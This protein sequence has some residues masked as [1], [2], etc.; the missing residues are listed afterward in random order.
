MPNVLQGEGEYGPDLGDIPG[1]PPG[2]NHNDYAFPASH[3]AK[4]EATRLIQ[5]LTSFVERAHGLRIQ[6]LVAEL[7]QAHPDVF[8]LLAV[9]AVQWDTRSSKGRLGTFTD[10]W[11]DFMAGIGPP[12][13]PQVPGK[14]G[15]APGLL[16]S[17][18][19]Q[20]LIMSERAGF[21][22]GLGAGGYPVKSPPISPGHL[23]GSQVDRQYLSAAR[24]GSAPAVVLHRYRQHGSAG[25]NHSNTG[26]L[27]SG[28]A[29]ANNG[30]SSFRNAVA[31]ARRG[32]GGNPTAQPPSTDSYA[33][34][35]PG[36]ESR[37]CT[38]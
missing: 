7:V 3:K 2:W 9:H 29:G 19:K 34:V 16:Q 5:G 21:A 31:S 32:A 26:L 6:G 18:D 30:G 38:H 22:G 28:Y 35:S 14:R 1:G 11:N 36:C 12:P 8:V 25:F 13:A 23:P 10:R 20:V 15:Q 27:S 24:P 37:L 4:I 17:A 33:L